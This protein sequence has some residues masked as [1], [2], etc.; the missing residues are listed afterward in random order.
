MTAMTYDGAGKIVGI[1]DPTGASSSTTYDAAN[2]LVTSTTNGTTTAYTYNGWGTLVQ[3]C[4]Q[5]GAV[6]TTTDLVL[7]ER[8]G[9]PRVLGTIRSDGLTTLYAYGA[10]GVHAQ[11]TR[12]ATTTTLHYTLLDALG[13][14]RA[15]VTPSGVVERTISYDAWGTVRHTTGTATTRLG[16]TGEWMGLVDGTVYLR[17]RHYQPALGRFLQRD[18]FPDIPSS[19][20]SLHIYTCAHNN[21]LKYTDSSDHVIFVVPVL[22]ALWVV[23]EVAAAFLL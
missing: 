23:A 18:S 9:L 15:L 4:I 3:E 7:D 20:Q 12:T 19:P 16:Y 13:S 17:A 10:E 11:H 21:A 14:I 2:R 8:G 5:T 1:T 22:L 6:I